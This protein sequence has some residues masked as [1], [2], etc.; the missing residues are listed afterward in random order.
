M[1]R[2]KQ[3][4][5][6]LSVLERASEV[7]NIPMDSLSGLYLLGLVEISKLKRFLACKHLQ[8]LM[9]EETPKPYEKI[10]LAWGY[11]EHYVKRFYTQY[12]QHFKHL[13][14]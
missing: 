14:V 8:V 3:Y 13:S 7:L 1:T 11:T 5:E 9:E 12:P 6:N 2:I 4:K 10:A